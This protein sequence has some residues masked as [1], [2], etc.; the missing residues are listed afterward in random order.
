MTRTL[1]L[2]DPPMGR[3]Q[4]VGIVKKREVSA[5]D[6]GS[7]GAIRGGEPAQPRGDPRARLVKAPGFDWDAFTTLRHSRRKA[8]DLSGRTD[9]HAL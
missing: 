7:V 2:R 4:Q 6:A 5:D 8:R 1:A 9:C 3:S